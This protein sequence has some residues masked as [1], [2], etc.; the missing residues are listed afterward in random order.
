MPRWV[1]RFDAVPVITLLP[2]GDS[3]YLTLA[4]TRQA[5]EFL[6]LDGISAQAR[7]RQTAIYQGFIPGSAISYPTQAGNLVC[8]LV[9][10]PQCGLF[11]G[12][13][14]HGSP[15][16]TPRWPQIQG[17]MSPVDPFYPVTSMAG[18]LFAVF[19]KNTTLCRI[20]INHAQVDMRIT[21]NT[22]GFALY[23]QGNVLVTTPMGIRLPHLSQEERFN[24]G[25]VIQG[26]PVVLGNF[27]AAVGLGEGMVR[28]YD[29]S[30]L[31]RSREWTVSR[32]PAMVTAL[33]PSG[34]LLAAGDSNGLVKIGRFQFRPEATTGTESG[35]KFA[36]RSSL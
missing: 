36:Q 16:T 19:E 15:D 17:A 1:V 23:G 33:A 27:A 18:K 22:K 29:L 9:S 21:P 34:D 32:T 31:A 24:S 11:L 7:P 4:D 30:N 14:L 6:R 25:E 10:N 28:L 3:L 35:P 12:Q 8:F 13:V 2:V 26:H 5:G 20:D